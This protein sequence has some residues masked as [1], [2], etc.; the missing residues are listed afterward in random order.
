MSFGG[1][2]VVKCEQEDVDIYKEMSKRIWV[3]RYGQEKKWVES[4]E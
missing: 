1:R 4:C 2:R 3:G